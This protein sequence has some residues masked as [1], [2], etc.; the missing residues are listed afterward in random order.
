M[1]LHSRDV[2]K[3]Q[4]KVDYYA[5]LYDVLRRNV[6]PHPT[7]LDGDS[8]SELERIDFVFLSMDAVPATALS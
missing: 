3:A 4:R 7:R 5:N 6:V 1:L 2:T 8:V